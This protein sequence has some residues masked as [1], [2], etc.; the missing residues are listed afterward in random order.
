[1]RNGSAMLDY[2]T[3]PPIGQLIKI[4]VFNYTNIENVTRGVEKIIKLQEVGPYVYHER[5]VKTK[6][7]FEDH[8]IKSFVSISKSDNFPLI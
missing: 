7:T 1:M 5:F 6:L 8:K 2:W 3:N 4:Y